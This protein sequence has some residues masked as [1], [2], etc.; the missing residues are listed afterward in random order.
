MKTT[1]RDRAGSETHNKAHAIGGE[2]A[3]PAWCWTALCCVHCLSL[4]V[5]T[6]YCCVDCLCH[7]PMST[8][9]YLRAPVERVDYEPGDTCVAQLIKPQ[10]KF[11]RTNWNHIYRRFFPE[12]HFVFM[13]VAPNV[14]IE[15]KFG[16]TDMSSMVHSR[17]CAKARAISVSSFGAGL[18][19]QV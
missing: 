7:Q 16:K 13:Q 8:C 10:R 5:A 2:P 18:V 12:D 1:H 3:T 4:R 6:A 19:A 14:L 15:P 9:F 17:K 11:P